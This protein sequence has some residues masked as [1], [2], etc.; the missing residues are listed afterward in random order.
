MCSFRGFDIIEKDS[1][2]ITCLPKLETM[3][4][5]IPSV[6]SY[7]DFHTILINAVNS[8]VEVVLLISTC[9]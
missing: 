5:S 8:K 6:R 4:N 2:E 3:R 7:D 1:F 9:M